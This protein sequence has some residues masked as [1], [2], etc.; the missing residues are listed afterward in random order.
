MFFCLS[1]ALGYLIDFS[2]ERKYCSISVG[3][4][5]ANT[6]GMVGP[7]IC[8]VGL[9]YITENTT[10]AMIVLTTALVLEC[11]VNSGSFINHMDLSPNFAGFLT[12]ISL[13]GGNLTSIPVPMIIAY[14]VYDKVC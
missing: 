13:A 1:P 2:I 9:G 5:I 10:L 8:L 6:I 7:T 4:K 11:G 14:V 12:G 3:R